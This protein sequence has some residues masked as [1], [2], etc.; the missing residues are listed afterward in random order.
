[1][2]KSIAT[3]SLGGTLDRKLDA[4]AAAGFD[5]VEIFAPNL[6]NFAEGAHGVA[7]QAKDLGLA[8]DM[9]QPLRDIEGV[10]AARFD[11]NLAR[12]ELAF[13]TMAE[14]GAPL[15]LICANTLA[16]ASDDMERVAGQ[17]YEIAE[18]ARLRGVRLGYEAL[19]WSTHVNTFDRALRIVERVN[20]PALGLIL[21]SFH[22][23]IRPDDWSSL[24]RI[25]ADRIA[26]VQVG[27]A[28]R[29]ANDPLTVRRN[30]SRLPGD[31]DLAVAPFARAV[32]ATGYRGTMSL[33]IFNERT[34]LSTDDAAVAAMA[35]MQRL[36][37][38]ASE[39]LP[40]S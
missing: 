24:S 34:A 26:Y 2:R 22:T 8:I 36:E 32:L 21:D 29:V 23:L 20:H 25:A 13:D 39:S 5:G 9:F 11:E 15:L 18:R 10:A 38:L 16:D 31:G 14:L 35:A 6:E 3:V 17:L 40:T 19:A 28:V 4:I 37:R 30:H 12:A 7:K 27:D 33:E 1:M